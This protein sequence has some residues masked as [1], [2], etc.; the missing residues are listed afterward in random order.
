MA[1]QAGLD[2]SG[3]DLSVWHI[4]RKIGLS[5]GLFANALL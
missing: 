4:H 5:G 2:Q 1:W 3:I